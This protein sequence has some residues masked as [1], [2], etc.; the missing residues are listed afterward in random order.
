MQDPGPSDPDRSLTVR[1]ALEEEYVAIR[2]PLPDDYRE[3]VREIVPDPGK[4]GDEA[5]GRALACFYRQLHL[6]PCRAA[7][8]L[9]GGGIRS[10]T[11]GL[12]VLQ[13]LA[14]IGMLKRFTYLSTVSGG[15][16]IGSWLSAWT[17]RA[18]GA[19][20][21]EKALGAGPTSPLAVDADPVHHLRRFSNYL[22][23]RLGILSADTWTLA[24]IYLRNLVVNWLLLLPLLAI[25][26]LLPRLAVAVVSPATWNP[27][28]ST[29]WSIPGLVLLLGALAVMTVSLPGGSGPPAKVRALLTAADEPQFV[30]KVLVPLVGSAVALT[31]WW[32]WYALSKP[33]VLTLALGWFLLAGFALHTLAWIIYVLVAVGRSARA[34]EDKEPR[35]PPR[36]RA[37]VRVL[38]RGISAGASGLLG[39][40]LVWAAAT[41]VTPALIGGPAGPPVYAWLAMP[42]FLVCF[43]LAGTAFVALDSRDATEQDREWEARAGAWVLI[44]VVSWVV[45]GFLTL[46]GPTLLVLAWEQTVTGVAACGV[47][48]VASALFGLSK[49]TSGPSGEGQG[50]TTRGRVLDWLALAGAG[51]FLCCLVAALSLLLS[52][53]TPM[54]APGMVPLAVRETPVGYWLLGWVLPDHAGHVVVLVGTT[55]GAGMALLGVLAVAAGI[56]A[57]LVNVNVF[58]LHGMYRDRLVRAY[59]GASNTAR[60]PNQFTGFDEHDDPAMRAL[61]PAQPGAGLFHVVNIAL[62]LVR[63]RELAWQ[64]RKAESFT[65]TPL[66][67]GARRT[68]YRRLEHEG[69]YY[70]G[71]TGISLGTAMAISG[72]AA[73]PNMGYHSSAVVTFLMTLFNVRLGAWLGNP[74]DAWTSGLAGPVV[75]L[76]PLLSEALGLTDERSAYVNL[77]D[78]GHFDNLGLYEMVRRRC[79]LIVVSDAG[80]DPACSL[81]DL[82]NAVAKIR[83][84]FGVPI[85]FDHLDIRP[86]KARPGKNGKRAAIARIRYSAADAVPAGLTRDDLDGVLI[87]LKPVLLGDEP[88][89]VEAY[90]VSHEQFPH[91]STGD[92]WF[93]ETQ[94]ESYRALG[95]WTA[96]CLW[97]PDQVPKS[98][99]GWS[100]LVSQAARHTGD[101]ELPAV[102]RHPSTA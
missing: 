73:N 92:Q 52:V 71:R 101:S 57:L 68:G 47:S 55:F 86:R 75:G 100:E 59:L 43:L 56:A 24:G 85:E 72:A 15:G 82:G 48:G 16:Y 33:I 80:C 2:G 53:V 67:A 10:A 87:Y 38:R 19:E 36:A 44:V 42:L 17:L 34:Q 50:R 4:A 29:L 14:E 83:V 58:S 79:R 3:R 69:S 96:A 32:W 54:V 41:R 89:D 78:G 11:F 18:G 70:G 45:V 9:S 61:R 31:T 26:V 21:V 62:N 22:S 98:P 37:T 40:L 88:A 7:L 51:L 27:E 93:S 64:E 63:G 81:A 66:H 65:V 13:G 20:A 102:E 60:R 84:D 74:S 23:P 6:G 46:F 99:L 91:E 28:P 25:A 77:S 30:A 8:C 35:L 94:F 1:E 97:P 5:Q 95:R 39:G 49:W 12:G 90:A 76:R